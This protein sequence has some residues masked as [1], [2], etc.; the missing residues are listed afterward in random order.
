MDRSVATLV[1]LVVCIVTY[2]HCDRLLENLTSPDVE[3]TVAITAFWAVEAVY[4]ESFAHCIGEG[5]KTPQELKETCE[6]WGNEA[7]A[8]YCQS[9]ENIANRRLQKASD[10]E[11]KKAEVMFLN[12]LEHEVDFWNMSRGN[13]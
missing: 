13:V 3:Y 7:F 2:E 8:K 1:C 12:V 11:L 4:Q 9:V 10:E 5:S 6:R